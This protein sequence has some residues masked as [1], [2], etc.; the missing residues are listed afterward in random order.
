LL[1]IRLVGGRGVDAKGAAHKVKV[2]R[3]SFQ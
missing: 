2:C 3:W 1:L